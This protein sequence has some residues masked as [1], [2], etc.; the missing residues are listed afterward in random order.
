MCVD[1]IKYDPEN[2]E[3]ES[4][5]VIT[6]FFEYDDEIRYEMRLELDSADN[7]H[8]SYMS[9]FR[10]ENGSITHDNVVY[11]KWDG[12][13]W[14]CTDGQRFDP[15]DTS[16][17]NPANVSRNTTTSY[18][19]TFCLDSKDN[20]HFVWNDEIDRNQELF[21]VF[22]DGY[23]WVCYDGEI[24]DPENI[25]NNSSV[26][27]SKKNALMISYISLSLDKND[28]PNV[29]WVGGENEYS[30]D[31]KL[32][33]IKYNGSKWLVVDGSEYDPGSDTDNL[34]IITSVESEDSDYLDNELI[35]N[36]IISL[37][38]NETPHIIWHQGNFYLSNM[39]VFSTF[40]DLYY[41][42]WDGDKWVT[43]SGEEF[44]SVDSTTEEDAEDTSEQ[45]KDEE[46]ESASE[47]P[48][49]TVSLTFQVGS[50]DWFVLGQE[51]SPMDTAPVIKEDRTFIVIRY[52]VETIG[53]TIDWDPEDKSI[54]I[55]DKSK[56]TLITLQIGNRLANVDGREVDIDPDNPNIAPFIENG[57][58]LVPLRFVAESLGLDVAWD[59]ETQTITI[60]N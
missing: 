19:P 36:P 51:Q 13:Q 58:T 12:Q 6:D 47:E 1:G 31:F 39:I 14:A 46:S 4:S 60:H 38:D 42:T 23:D 41:I 25:D 9:D 22:W 52:V 21:Y 16:F 53:R 10:L 20:P 32:Y 59:G 35:L 8:V 48:D 18:F 30:N 27:V 17:Y 49:E 57:R 44:V 24:Y 7:P 45:E 43:A 33:Y 5:S 37:S 56:D 15:T 26:S 3:L 54:T 2:L 40:G 50:R 29:V 11:V 34:A 28:R 55:E